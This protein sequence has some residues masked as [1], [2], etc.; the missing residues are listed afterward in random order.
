MENRIVSTSIQK[1]V[2]I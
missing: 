2:D 1:Q